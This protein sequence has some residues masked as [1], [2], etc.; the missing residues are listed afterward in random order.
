MKSAKAPTQPAHTS[1]SITDVPASGTYATASMT[2]AAASGIYAAAWKTYVPAWKTY[3]NTGKID[4]TAWTTYASVLK[5]YSDAWTTR[6][7]KRTSHATLA[8][9]LVATGVFSTPSSMAQSTT[10]QRTWQSL[11]SGPSSGVLPIVRAITTWDPTPTDNI[12]PWL[13]AG[14]Q[15]AS[16]G[17]TSSGSLARWNG[18]SW[19]GLGLTGSNGIFAMSPW[20]PDGAGP[21]TPQLVIG[22]GI[23]AQGGVAMNG[24]SRF[25]GSNWLPFDPGFNA[26]VV[27]LTTWDPDGTGPAVAQLVAGGTFTAAGSTTLN[28]IARWGGTQ[29]QP[30][31]SGFDGSVNA[32]TTW[33]RD[34]DGPASPHLVAAGNFL[35]AGSIVVNRVAIWDLT[36]WRTLAGGVNLTVNEMVAWD[37]DALGPIQPQLILAGFF[38]QAGGVN[39]GGLARW[40]GTQWAAFPTLSNA[41]VEAVTTWD[42][43]L[44]PTTGDAVAIGIGGSVMDTTWGSTA[45]RSLG[46]SFGGGGSGP[47]LALGKYADAAGNP[48]LVTGGTFT[49]FGPVGETG[50]TANGIAQFACRLPAA[51]DDI[52]FNNNNVFP[53]DADVIEFFNVLAG[54]ECATC[55]DIDFN[56]NGVF[57]EDQDVIDFFNVL[58]GGTCP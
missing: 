20:D 4:A 7:G 17:G 16:T 35:N 2:H 3:A 47:V 27:A 57:P 1:Q 28:R 26:L 45:W 39:A 31:G 12:G 11:A 36:T 18:S 32:L 41:S 30:I 48:S 53:E 25:D 5:S 13:V 6:A 54:A 42:H 22:G 55:N 14:G 10:C 29:W 8:A 33:D 43:D 38:T 52:D 40:D 9:C 34:G 46:W 56:N 37:P 19:S 49:V 21:A 58:A 44:N 50:V 51:C 23:G 24:I 15:F